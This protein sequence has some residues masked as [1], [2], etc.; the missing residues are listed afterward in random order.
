MQPNSATTR[1]RRA[2]KSVASRFWPK[3]DRRGDQECWPWT[4]A[5]NGEMGYGTLRRNGKKVP[6]HCI[7]WEL[8]HGKPFPEGMQGC[9]TCDNPPCVNPLH[10]FPGTQ[11]DNIRDAA[12][13]G[14]LTRYCASKT[15]CPHG[16]EYTES[17]TYRYPSGAR[18]CRVCRRNA[19]HKGEQA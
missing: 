16:H 13:K 8:H 7:S 6:A 10:I 5:T 14:R 15:H 2:I 3:V 12:K 17:N 4:A 9:H 18:H 11:L 1:K 19:H